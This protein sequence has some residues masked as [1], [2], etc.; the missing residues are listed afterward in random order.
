MTTTTRTARPEMK[1]TFEERY[2]QLV[3]DMAELLAEK[4]ATASDE[5]QVEALDTMRE[6]VGMTYSELSL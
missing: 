2:A 6:D 5:E 4:Y 1:K 3:A